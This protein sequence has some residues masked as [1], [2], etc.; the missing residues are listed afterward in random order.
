MFFLLLIPQ[1]QDIFETVSGHDVKGHDDN[2]CARVGQKPDFIIV[3]LSS[4]V[5]N[6]GNILED[7]IENVKFLNKNLTTNKSKM[8]PT[9][10]TYLKLFF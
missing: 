4:R 5:V 6:S 7:Q 9:K 10:I 2:F 3:L 8:F 1:E